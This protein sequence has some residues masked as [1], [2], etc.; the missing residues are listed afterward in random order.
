MLA[1]TTDCTTG[2]HASLSPLFT[3]GTG[4]DLPRN[5][6]GSA[7]PDHQFTIQVPQMAGQTML[8]PNIHSLFMTLGVRW[9]GQWSMIRHH[10]VTYCEQSHL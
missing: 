9:M 7:V 10:A 5:L 6:V 8:Q 1:S 4:P 2:V 3:M